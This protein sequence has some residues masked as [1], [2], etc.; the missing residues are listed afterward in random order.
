M[1]FLRRFFAAWQDKVLLGV[2]V[3]IRGDVVIQFRG[4]GLA[5][6][7]VQHARDEGGAPDELSWCDVTAISN[8]NVSP[9]DVVLV[10]HKEERGATVRGWLVEV[11]NG[12]YDA[13]YRRH[14]A[15]WIRILPLE[16]DNEKELEA[17][18]AYSISIR[19]VAI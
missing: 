2:P 16:D 5:R 8:R 13:T 11:I 4:Q 1:N 6:F 10:D 3:A 14:S 7:R 12:D 15:D 18:L 17:C 19:K 9:D